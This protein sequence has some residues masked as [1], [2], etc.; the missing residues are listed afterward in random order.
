VQELILE[1]GVKNLGAYMRPEYRDITYFSGIDF[2]QDIIDWPSMGPHFIT[3]YVYLDEVGEHDAPLHVIPGSHM[4]GATV[5]PH[6]LEA[7]AAAKW[8]YD[9]GRGHSAVHEHEVL[10]GQAGDVRLWHPFILHGT[11]PDRNS[12]PR[13]SVRYLIQVADPAANI[14]CL[15]HD[16][17]ARVQGPLS[18]VETRKDLDEQGAAIV[19]GNVINSIPN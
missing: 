14:D 19:K 1:N 16:L 7:I 18:L 17:N 6:Q 13:I 5:F 15:L 8:R 2:H 4:F 10:T 9:D 3:M 11:Q 12:N